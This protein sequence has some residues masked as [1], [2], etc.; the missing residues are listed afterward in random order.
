[1][2]FRLKSEPV[3]IPAYGSLLCSQLGFLTSFSDNSLSK[4]LEFL[5]KG[6]ESNILGFRVLL[7]S[8]APVLKTLY[9]HLASISFWLLFAIL[10]CPLWSWSTAWLWPVFSCYPSDE[11][12]LPKS[13]PGVWVLASTSEVLLTQTS[14]C[15]QSYLFPFGFCLLG[16][17][18]FFAGVHG[19]SH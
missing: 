19:L 13:W 14:L 1:M 5:S 7:R 16:Q 3:W 15:L 11:H 12:H 9:F 18:A 8:H 17:H 6:P 2:Y 4:P 10:S